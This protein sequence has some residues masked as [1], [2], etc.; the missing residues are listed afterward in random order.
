MQIG[1]DID[2]EAAN[3]RSGV[4][5]SLN[6][7][8]NRIAIGATHNDGNGTNRWTC[9]HIRIYRWNWLKIG[10]DI[11]GESSNDLAGQVALN[12]L[13]DYVAL[14]AEYTDG[15]NTTTTMTEDM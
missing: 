7:L 3:D 11:D 12:D 14:G 15:N 10:Q 2:G 13:G 8:G 1:Q 5:I 9:K 6:D 4:S